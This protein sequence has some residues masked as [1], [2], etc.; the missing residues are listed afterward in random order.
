MKIKN[1]ASC[2][3]FFLGGIGIHRFYLGKT[4]KGIFSLIFFW[5]YIPLI[6]GMIDFVILITMSEEKFNLK[7][8]PIIRNVNSNHKNEETIPEQLV[9]KWKETKQVP[10]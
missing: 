4:A 3:A 5:T 10:I 1:T 7:Y 6:I 8:N 2:L 9:Q